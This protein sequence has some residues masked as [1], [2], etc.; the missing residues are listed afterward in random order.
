MGTKVSSEL[1]IIIT[2]SNIDTKVDY[3]NRA[4]SI[5]NQNGYTQ[6]RYSTTV[7]EQK[8]ASPTGDQNG[9]TRLEYIFLREIPAIWN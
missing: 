6:F 5:R 4:G 9:F 7:Y 8:R 3:Q 1:A 2:P